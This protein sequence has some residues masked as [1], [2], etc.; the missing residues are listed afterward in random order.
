VT[1]TIR[2]ISPDDSPRLAALLTQLGYP[3]STSEV[4]ERLGYWLPDPNSAL[5]GAEVDGELVGVA[6][7]HLCPHLERTGRWARLAALVVDERCRGTG[8]GAA[9]VRAAED[10]ARELG[11]HSMEI[12][13]SRW[14]TGAHGFYQRLGYQDACPRSARFLKSLEA[15]R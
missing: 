9:L 12:T 7:L 1:T 4:V 10:R 5:I 15:G 8:V 6:A 3:A 13:S 14:R 11:C 2:P